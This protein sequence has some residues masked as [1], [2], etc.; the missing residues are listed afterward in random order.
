MLCHRGPVKAISVDRE[1]LYLATSG[2]DGIMKIWDIR[3]YK[4]LHKHITRSPAGCLTFSQRGLLAAGHG[5]YVNIWKDVY[6]E[7]Q[8]MPYMKHHLLH[9]SVSDLEFCPFEDV[10]G[11]G[12]ANGFSSLLI[13]GAGEP[14]FDALESNPYQTKRQRQEGEV[15]ALLEKIPPELISLDPHKINK[16][17]NASKDVLLQEKLE[18]LEEEKFEPRYK[19]RGKSS[20]LRTYQRKQAHMAEK[21]RELKRKKIFTQQKE[22]QE[23]EPKVKR[24]ALDRFSR[25]AY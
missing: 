9:S 22:T 11:V 3:T 14:N 12:H 15:K 10:L 19:T 17:D 7:K 21:I 4:P 25:R 6:Q 2:L 24:K 18:K 20:S 16:M 5:S 23:E 1:G 8:K 13:P